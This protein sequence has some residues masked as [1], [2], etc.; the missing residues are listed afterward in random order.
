MKQHFIEYYRDGPD[1]SAPGA[2]GQFI[3]PGSTR[4]NPGSCDAKKFRPTKSSAP[5]PPAPPTTF[6]A[7]LPKEK[8]NRRTRGTKIVDRRPARD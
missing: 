6:D 4:N 7:R 2:F 8:A 3:E 5:A 1:C